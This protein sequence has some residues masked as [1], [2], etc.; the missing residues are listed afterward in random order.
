MRESLVHSLAQDPGF[1]GYPKG[2]IVICPDCW[3]PIYVLERGVAPGDRAGRAASAFR[4]MTIPDLTGMLT[5][6]DIDAGWRKLFA[7]FLGTKAVSTLLYAD[8][9][10]AGDKA[11]CPLCAGTWLRFRAVTLPEALDQAYVLEMATIAPFATAPTPWIGTTTR[12]IGGED[13]EFVGRIVTR[14]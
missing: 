11:I 5:R 3:K 9:P 1:E 7:E 4:P 12:W 8:R 2:S 6:P 13:D 14:H 10:K